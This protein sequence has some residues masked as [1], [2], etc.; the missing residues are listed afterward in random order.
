MPVLTLSFAS[1]K[2]SIQIRISKKG[3]L[4]ATVTKEIKEV[5]TN[6]N[7]MWDTY[8]LKLIDSFKKLK[9]LG[10]INY[11]TFYQ[12]NISIIILFLM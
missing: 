10:E 6:R 7:I 2:N 3:N 1:D 5:L 11:N 4:L 12:S 9:V 8:N